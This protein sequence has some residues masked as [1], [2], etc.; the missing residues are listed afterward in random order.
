ME[1]KSAIITG[2]YGSIGFAI[3]RKIAALPNYKV[4]LLGRNEDMLKKACREIESGTSNPYVF[5]K[6]ADLSLKS[7]IS[8]LAQSWQGPLNLLVNNAASCPRSRT[9]NAEGIEMQFATNVLAYIRMIRSFENILKES[10]P[11]RI[12]NVASYWA[13][14]LDLNDL[15]F[16][17]RRYNNDTAYRQCKQANRMTTAAL[18]KEYRDYGIT[19][20]ACHPGDV[21]SKLSNSL[22]YG[23]HESPDQGASTPVWVATSPDLN[24][25]SGKYFEHL[26]EQH[27]PFSQ[28]IN[29]CVELLKVC[30]SY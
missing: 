19:V 20:N 13:G 8:S 29:K 1:M 30:D 28:D 22:G 21:N 3:A 25:I 14:N 6:V 10:A 5:Y 23:G 15:E 17:T 16:K 12:V 7:D 11:A 4:Y 9:E 24:G 26:A 2:A 27:C 18:A